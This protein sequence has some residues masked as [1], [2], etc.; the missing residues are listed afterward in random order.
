MSVSKPVLIRGEC[1]PVQMFRVRSNVY[2][3][4]FHPEADINEFTL[5]IE[6][7][8]NHGYFPPQEARQLVNSLAG[9]P[10]PCAQE[11]LRRFVSRYRS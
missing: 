8:K 4:Q 1:C 10:T 7:Y 5:R 11:L 9:K 2:A 3:T 6:A